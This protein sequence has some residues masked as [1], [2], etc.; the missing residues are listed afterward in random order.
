[1]TGIRR[2]PIPEDKEGIAYAQIDLAEI[3]IAKMA[4]DPTGHYAR[5]DV[6]RL[7]VNRSP[8]RA[9]E[10]KDDETRVAEPVMAATE[11]S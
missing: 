9:I 7:V 10:Y 8:R 1:M 3:A 2:F 6:T 11:A 4:A 5:G